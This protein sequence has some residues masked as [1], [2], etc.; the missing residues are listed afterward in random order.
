[1]IDSGWKLKVV[2]HPVYMTTSIIV[3]RR[4]G[5]KTQFFTTKEQAVYEIKEVPENNSFS[6]SER[7]PSLV[8]FTMTT[9]MQIPD[10]LQQLQKELNDMGIKDPDK[11]FSE[12]KL[13]ATEKHLEDLRAMLDL[14]ENP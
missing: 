1:M 9:M 6:T 4:A 2:T 3:Y 7:P 10:L 12:G 14:K 11:S 13:A 5:G 8:D